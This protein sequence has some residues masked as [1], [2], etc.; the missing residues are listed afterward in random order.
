MAARFFIMSTAH[1]KADIDLTLNALA[2]SL[3]AMD[4]EGAFADL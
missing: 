2:D 3:D 1:S 4:T